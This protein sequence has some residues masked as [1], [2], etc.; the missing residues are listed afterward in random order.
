MVQVLLNGLVVGTTYALIALGLTI[1]FSIMKVVNFAH[2]QLYMIGGFIVYYFNVVF[3][4]PFAVGLILSFVIVAAIG[5]VMELALFRP[6]ML[7]VKREEVTLLLAMGTAVLLESLAL[8]VFGE[9]QRGVPPVVTGVFDVAG[10][11]LPAG[12]ALVLAAAALLIVLLMLFITYTRH[13]RALRALAQ[14]RDATALQG[15]NL[16]WLSAMGFGLGAGLA[17]LAGGLLVSVFAVYYGAGTSV[18]IKAFL[19]IMI[20]GAGVLSGAILGGFVLGFMESIGYAFLPGSST[21]L[22]IFVAVIL[23]LILRPQGIMGKPWG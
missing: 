23:F 21:S 1:V 9:K 16:K 11:F 14:D 2:G 4:L 6:V 22:L 7:R 19:M 13:G 17:G 3:D 8:L 15:V 5:V 18:S 20:G 12:R 10:A